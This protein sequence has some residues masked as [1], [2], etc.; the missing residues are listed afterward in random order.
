MKYQLY[1][2]IHFA[3]SGST[4]LANELDKNKSI[5]VTIEENLPDGIKKGKPVNIKNTS[6]LDDY[7]ELLYRDKKFYSWNIKKNELRTRLLEAY[8]FPLKFCDILKA[9]H[10]LYFEALRPEIVIHKQG[11]Y[12]FF[13]GKV[14]TEFPK[15]GF[16]FIDRDPRAIHNSQK[17]SRKSA[18]GKSMNQ[19][20]V[21]FALSY[22]RV[23]QMIRR[24][25]TKDYFYSLKYEDFIKNKI[26]EMQKLSNFLDVKPGENL[27]TESYYSRIPMS[28]KYLHKSVGGSYDLSRTEGWKEELEDYRIVF[29]QTALKQELRDKD[30]GF[31]STNSMRPFQKIKMMYWHIIFRIAHFLLKSTNWHYF[32]FRKGS[33]RKFGNG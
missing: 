9:I 19:G 7:L 15:A 20:I 30:Y 16:L 22:K 27:K 12:S 21:R 13:L 26:P 5:G 31:Y 11:N 4:L 24:Y 17:R 8:S 10:S 29:L 18:S 2:L 32:S 23:H 33:F 28:Q 1:F 3:R 25:I 6:D 14:K